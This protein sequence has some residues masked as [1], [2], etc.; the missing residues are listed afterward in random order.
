MGQLIRF[1]SKKVTFA[2]DFSGISAIATDGKLHLVSETPIG[3]TSLLVEPGQKGFVGYQFKV[4]VLK[5]LTNGQ[6]SNFRFA[7]YPAQKNHHTT[8]RKYIRWPLFSRC[9]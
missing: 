3:S 8:Q 7:E 9:D 1:H 5:W 6:Q 4:D 2:Y